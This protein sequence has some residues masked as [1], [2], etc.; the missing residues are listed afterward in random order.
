M[1][2]AIKTKK[3]NLEKVRKSIM[4]KAVPENAARIC[5]CK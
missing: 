5:I 1:G 2:P 3:A 4:E